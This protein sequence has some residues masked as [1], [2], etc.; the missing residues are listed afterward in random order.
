MIRYSLPFSARS[1]LL[2]SP[3]FSCIA[4][5]SVV[6]SVKVCRLNFSFTHNNYSGLHTNIH[7]DRGNRKGRQTRQR[8]VSADGRY[9]KTRPHPRPLSTMSEWV[10]GGR[11][12][13]KRNELLP[14]I[15][16]DPDV[17]EEVGGLE[18]A[19]LRVIRC[20]L[21]DIYLNYCYKKSR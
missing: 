4:G 20:A 1:I 5:H 11:P 15:T 9:N 2:Y 21:M 6:V 7:S 3:A 16:V 19:E 14:P 13:Y 10:G 12:A 17:L 8:A 18:E